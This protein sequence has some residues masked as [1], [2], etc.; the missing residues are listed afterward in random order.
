VSH[1][2]ISN[3]KVNQDHLDDLKHVNNVQYLLWAQDIAK[4]HWQKIN[5]HLQ[6]EG[7]WMV[8]N[9]EVEYRLGGFLGELIRIETYVKSV[10]GPLSQRVVEFYN[11]KSNQLMVSCKTQ[12]CYVDL[13]SRKPI[14]ISDQI[15]KLFLSEKAPF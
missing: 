9:H 2:Y 15:E 7:V 10:K 13:N 8:R 11:D 4:A 3:V 6:Q 14:R 1:R 12:W 5:S